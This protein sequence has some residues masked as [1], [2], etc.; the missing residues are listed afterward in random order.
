MRAATPIVI[1]AYRPGEA[2]IGL[3]QTLL[4]SSRSPILVVDDGSGPDYEGI[5]QQVASSD[6][7][8][9][10][11]HAVNLGKGAALKTAMNRALLL[12]P[13]AAGVVTADADGQH[14]PTDILRVAARLEE[15]PDSLV[16]GVRTFEN[17]PLRSWFGNTLT[18]TLMNA[19]VG[20][21]LSDTQTGLRGIP[22]ELIPHLLALPS[23]GYE[24]ELD[25]LITAKHQCCKIVQV[26]IETI[27]IGRNESSHFHPIF[28][29]MRIYVLLFRFALVS[30]STAAIDNVVFAIAFGAGGTIA[31]SQALGRIV[32]MVFNF[33][34][35]RKFVFHSKQ[36]N[37][38]LVPKY[39]ALVAA[40]GLVSYALI[41]FL[42]SYAAMATI[43][44]KLL[45]EGLL[46][47]ANFA[48]QRD[49]V[50]TARNRA[51]TPWDKYYASVP[52]TAKLSRRYT[53][54]VLIDAFRNYGEPRAGSDLSVT[55][56]GG[57]NSCFVDKILQG[58]PCSSYDVVDTNQYGLSLLEQRLGSGT[59]VRLHK[60]SVLAMEMDAPADLVFSVGLVEH[61]DPE[62]TR[63][64]VLAHFD[65][66]R[67]GGT[68]VITFPTPTLLYRMARGFIE[69]LGM[70]KFH[71][72]RPLKPDEVIAAIQERGD[73]LVRKTLWPLVL[74]QHLI[75]A[76]RWAE[77]AVATAAPQATISFTTR[78]STSVS[79]KS[80]PLRR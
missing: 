44:A 29:S 39:L 12:F 74:T 55:E 75:V 31:Q 25:M 56:I 57:A 43:P 20:T 37:T 5:F 42:Q 71:D 72:E 8:H 40:N 70:W 14:A 11:R 53:T 28:D 60:Q 79:L 68:V 58:V 36:P 23:T 35:A 65:A 69:L 38:A 13:A 10:E 33:T 22:A 7:V 4:A 67:P 66:V 73:I 49:F 78:P 50:F 2:L 6:R 45:A 47:I 64:A 19:M 51:K 34:G 21:A 16:M 80:R 26:P 52:A 3:V 24:F 63:K 1:P 48:I 18:R 30:L 27:Y 62:D 59:V 9:L 54:G 15:N 77:G 32:A 17:A 76:R 46:F 61:F 41:H